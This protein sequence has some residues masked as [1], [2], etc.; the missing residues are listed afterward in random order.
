MFERTS[1]DPANCYPRFELQSP[2]QIATSVSNLC[3]EAV[4]HLCRDIQGRSFKDRVIYSFVKLFKS[5]VSYNKNLCTTLAIAEIANRK[6]ITPTNSH[7]SITNELW[8]GSR[9][10]LRARSKFLASLLTCP[11]YNLEYGTHRSVVEGMLAVLLKRVG[12]LV[13]KSVFGEEIAASNLPGHISTVLATTAPN[14]TEQI[15]TRLEA[16]Q[17]KWILRQ[18]TM[19]ARDRVAKPND[20]GEVSPKHLS[21]LIKG[22]AGHLETNVDAILGIARRKVQETLLKGLFGADGTEFRLALN[23]PEW[24]G[25]EEE[26]VVKMDVDANAEFVEA[27]WE[28]VGWEILDSKM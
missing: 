15:A 19:P 24:D 20:N 4:L 8:S 13:S 21:D 25:E 7:S 23:I 26:E 3:T 12:E 11:T 28:C 27:A 17:M 9:H 6:R 2:F 18:I 16:E 14:E 1:L 10:L 5:I 22:R